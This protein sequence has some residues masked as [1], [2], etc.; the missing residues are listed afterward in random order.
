MLGG[1]NFLC[2]NANGSLTLPSSTSTTSPTHEKKTTT[3]AGTNSTTN[4]TLGGDHLMEEETTTAGTAGRSSSTTGPCGEDAVRPSLRNSAENTTHVFVDYDAF[5][6]VD[7]NDARFLGYNALERFLMGIGDLS[8]LEDIFTCVPPNSS[9]ASSAGSQEF[10]SE[11]ASMLHAVGSVLQRGSGN[12]GS[13]AGAPGGLPTTTSPTALAG[14]STQ[15]PWTVRIGDE[16]GQYECQMVWN[17]AT[18]EFRWQKRR[19]RDLFNRT[20]PSGPEPWTLDTNCL[21]VKTPNAIPHRPHCDVCKTWVRGFAL[22]CAEVVRTSRADIESFL[23]KQFQRAD[24]EQ[25]LKRSSPSSSSSAVAPLLPRGEEHGLPLTDRLRFRSERARRHFQVAFV[26]VHPEFSTLP[27][28]THLTIEQ[29]YFLKTLTDLTGTSSPV[30]FKGSDRGTWANV[31]IGYDH[32]GPSARERRVVQNS[33]RGLSWAEPIRTRSIQEVKDIV[34]H[35]VVDNWL[36]GT[37]LIS[38]LL[39]TSWWTIGYTGPG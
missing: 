16:F 9:A 17:S 23:E 34:D 28:N 14:A 2:S 1:I 5:S 18:I 4:A 19:V 13:S 7:T 22:E 15:D 33:F 26:A 35:V 31:F 8:E 37:G 39:I 32:G 25:L 11:D 10:P 27:P 12:A 30:A 29:E 38:T 3:P 20:L 24:A 36:H 21:E 6:P